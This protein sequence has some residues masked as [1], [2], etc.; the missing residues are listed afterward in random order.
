MT[1]YSIIIVGAGGHGKVLAEALRA[2]SVPVCGF[3]EADSNR[4]GGVVLAVPVLGGD[5]IVFH[6]S[7]DS[8]RLINGVG[9][10]ADPTRRRAVYEKFAAR[11]FR[12]ESVI[13]PTAV[14]APDVMLGEG[15]QI[16]A[17]AI[18]QPGCS[19]GVDVIVNTGARIDHDCIVGDHAHIAP[20]AILCGNVEVGKG[21]H[22]GAGATIIQDTN[23]GTG[24]LVAAGGVVVENIPAGGKAAGVPAR[25]M[26]GI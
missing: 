5:D 21:T 2:S 4:H 7:P 20:G 19:I 11:G 24:A 16:M 9:S 26:N 14:I 17:G 12:F 18:I 3:V 8:V 22:I 25:K 15:A 6:S 1:L 10:T 23:I 13:H